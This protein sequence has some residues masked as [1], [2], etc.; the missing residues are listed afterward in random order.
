MRARNAHR[1]YAQDMIRRQTHFRFRLLAPLLVTCSACSTIRPPVRFQDES[2]DVSIILGVEPEMFP[3]TWLQAGIKAEASPLDRS[4]EQ[5][6]LAIVKRALA[7]YPNS[8]LHENLE[9]LYVVGKLDFSGITCGGT[10]S[11]ERLYHVNG[12]VSKWYTD[13]IIERGIHHEFSSIL[14]RNYQKKLNRPEWDAVLPVGFQYGDDGV[15]AVIDG[16][17]ATAL[18]EGMMENGFLSEYALSSF[19]N[20][21]N[22]I[23]ERLFMYSE[24]LFALGKKYPKLGKKNSIVIKFYHELNPIF[25][26]AYFRG[27]EFN[28][29]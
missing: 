21:F 19:E 23:A 4:E 25:T 16:K 5:R 13:E 22:L 20:D 24:A 28:L 11:R 1:A 9:R 14:L 10:N 17:A 27:S 15:Q 29:H 8:L 3:E 2:S 26:E 12:G 7:K 6:S 18:N